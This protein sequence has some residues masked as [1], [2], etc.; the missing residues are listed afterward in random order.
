M[1]LGT[2]SVQ[3]NTYS[4]CS[5]SVPTSSQSY[6]GATSTD[7]IQRGVLTSFQGIL[8]ITF[9]VASLISSTAF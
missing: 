7:E 8:V 4:H 3:P 2:S 5:A 9:L 6:L 1:I